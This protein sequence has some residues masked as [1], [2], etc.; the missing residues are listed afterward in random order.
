V[1]SVLS[2]TVPSPFEPAPSRSS[3]TACL[4][5]GFLGGHYPVSTLVEYSVEQGRQDLNLQPAVLET[6]ALPVELRP[7]IDDTAGTAI[8][9]TRSG[10]Y[11]IR[12][13][14][15]RSI[16]KPTDS[17]LDWANPEVRV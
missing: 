11:T 12:A 3:L 1:S 16:F 8:T 10:A 15:V 5:S 9:I 13:L 4:S 17:A 7:F 14:P 6:A 2:V